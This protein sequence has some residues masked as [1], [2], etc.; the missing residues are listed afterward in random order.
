MSTAFQFH[1]PLEPL[2]KGGSASTGRMRIGGIV[3]TEDRDQDGERILKTALDF[4]PFNRCGFFNDNHSK[5]TSSGVVGRPTVAARWVE[6][7][8]QLPTGKRSDRAGWWVEG[9]L[10]GDEGRKLWS[11]IKDLQG[12]DRQFGF[13]IQGST[14]ERDPL[15]KRTITRAVVRHVAVTHEP[16]NDTTAVEILAKALSAGSDIVNPGLAAGRGFPLRRESLAGQTKVL[17]FASPLE[18][19]EEPVCNCRGRN[20]GHT[21]GCPCHKGLDEGRGVA[22]LRKRYPHLPEETL[23]GLWGFACSL[24]KQLGAIA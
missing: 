22:V 7:G 15:D 2:H 8:E 5:S 9:E 24:K 10:F 17:E 23:K 21:S 19:G 18:G 13:S 3:S 14:H 11:Q 20:G 1:I 12:T 16:V 6:K 4:G